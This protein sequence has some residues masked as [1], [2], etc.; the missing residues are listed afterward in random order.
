MLFQPIHWIDYPKYYIRLLNKTII[1]WIEVSQ[2]SFMKI[3]K[4]K[5]CRTPVLPFQ[6]IYRLGHPKNWLLSL[7]FFFLGQSLP[8]MF[9]FFEITQNTAE[10]HEAGLSTS[11]GGAGGWRRLRTCECVEVQELAV[12]GGKLRCRQRDAIR[13]LRVCSTV[14]VT[15]TRIHSVLEPPTLR[16]VCLASLPLLTISRGTSNCWIAQGAKANVYQWLFFNRN[17]VEVTPINTHFRYLKKHVSWI[18][19]SKKYSIYFWEKTHWCL[20][21]HLT[22]CLRSK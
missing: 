12:R 14:I 17:I 11:D 9:F 20:Q 6:P 4:Q 19:V 5:P 18:K 3:W 1:F 10:H 8:N 2:K 7:Q 15:C 13:Q 21:G 22:L 16:P